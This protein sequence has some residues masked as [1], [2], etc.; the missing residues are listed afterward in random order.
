MVVRHV[1][2]QLSRKRVRLCE[3]VYYAREGAS[4][5][6]A[7][8]IAKR[9]HCQSFDQ[10]LCRRYDDKKIACAIARSSH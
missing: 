1:R 6:N 2:E 3:C 7:R 8:N 4:G 5:G 10:S 9:V